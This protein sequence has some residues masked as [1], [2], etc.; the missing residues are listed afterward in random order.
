MKKSILA[1]IAGAIFAT[2][3]SV[4]ADEL[5]TL[6]GKS[7]EGQFPV[8][9]NGV[10]LEQQAIVVDGTSHLPVRAIADALNMDISF[11][12]D[13]GIEVSE[14]EEEKAM[15]ITEPDESPDQQKPVK[16]ISQEDQEAIET[17]EEQISKYEKMI[18]DEENRLAQTI[19]EKEKIQADGGDFRIQDDL[20]KSINENIEMYSSVVS[21]M[22]TYKEEIEAK[23][24]Q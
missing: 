24:Q 2:A 20:I 13:L 16:V 7:I 15:P 3:G 8:K 9:V 10:P 19:E 22:E 1:F 5:K 11:N 6:V 14:K 21:E 12:S 18:D 4:Y 23:Y 17:A